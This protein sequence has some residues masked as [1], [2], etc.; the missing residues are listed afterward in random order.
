M[1]SEEVIKFL[2]LL[3]EEFKDQSYWEIKE[4]I[5]D[6]SF[7]KEWNCQEQEGVCFEKVWIDQQ[8][9]GEDLYSGYEYIQISDNKYIKIWFSC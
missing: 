9:T 5:E 4:I 7:K 6:D 2:K 3:L 8:Q 1:I